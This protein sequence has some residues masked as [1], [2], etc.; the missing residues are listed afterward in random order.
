MEVFYS[1]GPCGGGACPDSLARVYAW[2]VYA[3]ESRKFVMLSRDGHD[4]TVLEL[5]QGERGGK[6]AIDDCD[7]RGNSRKS[8]HHS[9][10]VT[11]VACDPGQADVFLYQDG[12]R[13]WKSYIEI[14]G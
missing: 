5:V 6:A 9:E 7:K 14:G 2:M 8:L 3:G 11:I 12:V 13:V 1:P 10:I 4:D